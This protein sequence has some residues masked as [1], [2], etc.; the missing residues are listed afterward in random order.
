MYKVKL[1]FVS[2]RMEVGGC[3]AG[4][5]QLKTCTVPPNSVQLL[6][7]GAE[8]TNVNGV[9]KYGSLCSDLVDSKDV[10]PV[11]VWVIV[12]EL[13]QMTDS[14]PNISRS[15]RVVKW[16]WRFVSSKVVQPVE[17]VISVWLFVLDRM[18]SVVPVMIS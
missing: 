11:M 12:V 4:V 5:G 9:T 6:Q 18:V 7:H 3:G 8:G 17:S 2:I 10:T 14:L 15:V 1:F 16:P 13:A